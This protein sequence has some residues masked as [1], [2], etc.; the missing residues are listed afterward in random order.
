MED[1][2]GQIVRADDMSPKQLAALLE[3]PRP[4]VCE[5]RR[6]ALA[7]GGAESVAVLGSLLDASGSFVA[8]E[9]AIFA[10]A[11]N[12]DPSAILPLRKALG[13]SDPDLL[14]PAVRALAMRRDAGSTLALERLLMHAAPAVRLSAAEGL[15]EVG[16]LSSVGALW[17]AL[18]A[19]SDPMLEHALIYAAGQLADVS[20]L[21]RAL[22]QSDPKVQKA[23]LLLLDQPPRPPDAL[24]HHAVVA[25]LNSPNA[26]LRKAAREILA[27][28]PEWAGHSIDFLRRLLTMPEISQQEQKELGDLLRAFQ[29]DE[30]V[31][32]L[33]AAAIRNEDGKFHDK[34]REWLLEFI[35]RTTL[36]KVPPVWIDSL[37]VLVDRGPP[38]IRM[39]AVRCAAVLQISELDDRLQ[40]LANSSSEPSELRREALRATVRRHPMLRPE[41]FR[42]LIQDLSKDAD[43]L[44]RL[45]AAETF[46]K[47]TLDGNQLTE[48]LRKVDGDAL[49]TPAGLLPMLQRSLTS[50]TS[51]IALEY[52]EESIQ[53]G[54]QPE[55]D[56]IADIV[57]KLAK[58]D[59]P[60]LE[61]A[62]QTTQGS[63]EERQARLADF[64]PLLDGGNA[65]RGR[66]VFLSKKA[67]CSTC[68]RVGADGGQI[69]PDLTRIG[70]IR[71]G[72]DMIESIVYP[73]STIAQEFE[74]YEI[75]T[76]DGRMISGMLTQQTAD[77]VFVR[78]SSGAETRVHKDD[79]DEMD[80]QATSMMPEGMDRLLT[81][82]EL[83]DLLAF[84][85]GQK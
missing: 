79:I 80:R 72:R 15:A 33:V 54:W 85:Q 83:R 58:R 13:A 1:P 52:L 38:D 62:L 47:T 37:A 29:T 68:H 74:Q 78:D 63:V 27:R 10:L 19:A 23:A 59:R 51:R 21:H 8:K 76:T 66:D 61:T 81:R 84:L 71:A 82:E 2:W 49:I 24:D 5:R 75:V 26:E 57:D 18:A 43:P 16:S 53:G 60:R 55:P 25:R 48:L 41:S 11:A 69:G 50:N 45:G 40:R 42:L 22:Q 77:S 28:H 4:Q 73:S 56:A 6:R 31:Q 14:I 64:Q 17:Q 46:G 12:D 7:A 3:D 67:A 70:A 44:L 20:A 32:A 39:A 9:H 36:A 65:E 34:Q 35:S 30:Q